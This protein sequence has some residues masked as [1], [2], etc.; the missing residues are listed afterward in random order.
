MNIYACIKT[1]MNSY[2]YDCGKYGG[3]NMQKVMNMYYA[4]K[5][6]VFKNKSSRNVMI[7]F[8]L[9]ICAV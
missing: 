2:S 4:D 1:L 7:Y 8:L 3:Q 5:T 6:H 9:Y